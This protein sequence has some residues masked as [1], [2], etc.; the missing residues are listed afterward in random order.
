[1]STKNPVVMREFPG[2]VV[3]LGQR[4][5]GA[6]QCVNTPGVARKGLVSMRPHDTADEP[7]RIPI[8]TSKQPNLCAL[9]DPE[10]AELVSRYRWNA[11]FRPWTTYAATVRDRKTL[12]MHRLIAVPGNGQVV[13]HINHDGLDNRRSN[14]RL[15]SNVE[16]MR[17]RAGAPSLNLSGFLGVETREG[18]RFRACL[19][20]NGK[21]LIVGSFGT[22]EEA[23]RARDEAAK[24]HFGEFAALNFPDDEVA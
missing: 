12:F 21:R 14:L 4:N 13:D 10:D 16:N 17:N 23:A 20:K 9:V 15:C 1:M 3:Q 19:W 7:I 5:R 18:G 11:H 6:G 22:P 8:Y 2:K 24:V